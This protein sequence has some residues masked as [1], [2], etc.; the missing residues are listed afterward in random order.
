MR[1]HRS[2][3]G[4]TRVT[5]PILRGCPLGDRTGAR[6]RGRLGGAVEGRGHRVF[7]QSPTS[8]LGG[9][10]AEQRRCL[11]DVIPAFVFGGQRSWAV[12]TGARGAPEAPAAPKASPAATSP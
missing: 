4:G 3:L 5:L 10:R 2:R 1:A 6:R 11:D 12:Q 8:P 7:N 9:A